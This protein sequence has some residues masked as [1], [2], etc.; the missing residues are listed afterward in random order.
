MANEKVWDRAFLADHKGSSATRDRAFR[1]WR[2]IEKFSEEKK[3]RLDPATIT[4]KQLRIFLEDRAQKISARSVQNEA[5]HLR[6][7]IEGTGRDI[8]DV[9][10]PKNAWSSARL[11]VP[12]GSRIGGKAAASLELYASKRE[13]MPSDV[14]SGVGLVEALGLRLKEMIESGNSLS[15]WARELSKP[16]SKERGCFLKVVDGTKGGRPRFVFIPPERISKVEAANLAA[17][18]S[19]EKNGCF[20]VQGENLKSAMARYSNC[21]YSLDLR[22][23][24]S[25]HGLRRAFAQAQYE[26]YR[27]SGLS[28]KVALMRLSQDLGHGDGRGRWVF[29]NYLSGGE[30]GDK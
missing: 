9:R 13:K 16:E 7:A 30:G 21:L 17:S 26:Y 23:D 15:A 29:N 22:G 27:N 12:E 24:D 1:T 2:A 19:A 14:G 28:E 3:W 6:R 20:I 11:S 25:G 4:P 18:T 5:S 8:G 10:D